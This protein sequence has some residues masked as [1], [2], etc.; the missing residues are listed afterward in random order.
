M[1]VRSCLLLIIAAVAAISKSSHLSAS[2][3]ATVENIRVTVTHCDIRKPALIN[4]FGDESQAE[5]ELLCVRLK[6][7][8]L[9]QTKKAEYVGW[10]SREQFLNGAVLTDEHDNHYRVCTFGIYRPSE[11]KLNESIYPGKSVTDVLVFQ[12]P[13]AAAT[14]LTLKLIGSR[15]EVE[16]DFELSFGWRDGKAD[17][18]SDFSR[19]LQQLIGQS[20]M[21][22]KVSVSLVKATSEMSAKGPVIKVKLRLENTGTKSV[23]YRGWAN[24]DSTMMFDERERGYKFVAGDTFQSKKLPAGESI[25]DTLTFSAPKDDVKMFGVFLPSDGVT[26]LNRKDAIVGFMAADIQRD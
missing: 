17:I 10:N 12:Q 19:D 9:S 16:K 2:E 25:E 4:D 11:G 7:E 18:P 26:G 22:G 24:Y 14:K 5:N 13:V 21:I 3:T 23:I 1:I 20:A 6:I 8:N 15:I